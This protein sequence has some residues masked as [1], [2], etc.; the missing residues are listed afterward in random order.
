MEEDPDSLVSYASAKAKYFYSNP[1]LGTAVSSQPPSIQKS[2][3]SSSTSF[4]EINKLIANLKVDAYVEAAMAD[5][6]GALFQSEPVCYYLFF[7]QS[8]AKVDDL[9]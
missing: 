5:R 7:D 2:P 8:K 9:V 1:T 4:T 6:V 3:T